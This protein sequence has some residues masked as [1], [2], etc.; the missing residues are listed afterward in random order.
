M[1]DR[2]KLASRLPVPATRPA[3]AEP[4]AR[5]GAEAVAVA[6]VA[7]TVLRHGLAPPSQG[8]VEARRGGSGGKPAL[9]LIHWRLGDA[10]VCEMNC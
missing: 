8:A 2:E 4:D 6:V 3:G 1:Q 9:N 7:R 10:T 5:A